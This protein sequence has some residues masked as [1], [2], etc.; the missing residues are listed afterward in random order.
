MLIVI[1][2]VVVYVSINLGKHAVN[3]C[4]QILTL[5]DSNKNDADFEPNFQIN[6]R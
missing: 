5:V 2:G 3:G 1:I 6:W 4:T